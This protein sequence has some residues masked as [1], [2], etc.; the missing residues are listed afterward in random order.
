M[1]F[2]EGRRDGTIP[3][4]I[5]EVDAEGPEIHEKMIENKDITEFDQDAYVQRI[6]E[7]IKAEKNKR[8]RI[9][10]V[11]GRQ[12]GDEY[13][14]EEME[15]Q[16]F[17]LI[18]EKF[19]DRIPHEKMSAEMT[20]ED[21]LAYERKIND[22][23]A[24]LLQKI[25]DKIGSDEE[26]SSINWKNIFTKLRDIRGQRLFFVQSAE[27][28]F[29]VLRNDRFDSPGL[30]PEDA[31]VH[32]EALRRF[33]NIPK[34]KYILS[35]DA[36][37]PEDQKGLIKKADLETLDTFLYD[38]ESEES[39]VTLVEMVR[40]AMKGALHLSENGL[41]LQDISF[42]NVALA[43]DEEGNKIGGV[44]PDLE[45]L[46]LENTERKDR[47]VNSYDS[48][49][50]KISNYRIPDFLPPE[51][52][53]LET[54]ALVSKPTV[55]KSSEMVFQFGE[56]LY[57]IFTSDFFYAKFSKSEKNKLNKL[58]TKFNEL[59]KEMKS[60]EPGAENPTKKRIS[61]DKALKKLEQLISDLKK[62]VS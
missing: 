49:I 31:K 3:S 22:L 17:L 39:L 59:S 40:D 62:I 20:N 34:N 53:D 1:F 54:G 27:G 8:E 60:F 7:S 23:R 43:K 19:F 4:Y 28:E 57:K 13:E 16:P 47:I 32:K 55:V 9:Y 21:Y 12:N 33:I 26:L 18:L 44:L 41:V 37:S 14:I 46:Y 24:K 38:E 2:S 15:E 52:V 5:A 11:S 10:L 42:T 35:Y 36:Y 25:I 30:R 50:N 48:N 61:L 58:V 45:G 56:C 29:K 51:T 6:V